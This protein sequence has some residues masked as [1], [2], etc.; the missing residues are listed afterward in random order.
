NPQVFAFVKST[1]DRAE[2]ALIVLNKDRSHAQ[3]CHVTALG[4]VFSGIHHIEDLSPE[5]RLQP[6]PD[7]R[8]ARLKPSGVHVLYAR[9]SP[10]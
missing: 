9:T 2:K 5:E 6:A 3:E 8:T 7:W 4:G 1:R 10:R